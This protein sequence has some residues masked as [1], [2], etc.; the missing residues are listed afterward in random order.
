MPK[1]HSHTD[2]EQIYVDLTKESKQIN[3]TE[4]TDHTLPKRLRFGE[5]NPG[6]M[7]PERLTPKTKMGSPGCDMSKLS[8]V[9]R[10]Q[11]S[12]VVEVMDV[13]SPGLVTIQ[14]KTLTRGS[15]EED[16]NGTTQSFLVKGRASELTSRR[17][18]F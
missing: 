18:S 15:V 9:G 2:S 6:M 16:R 8:H 3:Q 1:D 5:E 7:E 4:V 10:E 13:E 11:P 12:P 17:K 14:E